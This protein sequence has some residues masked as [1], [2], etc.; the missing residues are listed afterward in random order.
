VIIESLLAAAFIWADSN[1]LKL[2]TPEP[3][4]RAWRVEGPSEV[5]GSGFP[6]P[7]QHG[8][9]KSI[10]AYFVAAHCP[11]RVKLPNPQPPPHQPLTHAG[12]SPSICNTIPGGILMRR[13]VGNVNVPVPDR[14]GL[15]ARPLAA[16]YTQSNP[17]I[18]ARKIA[19]PPCNPVNPP[20]PAQTKPLPVTVD[21][22]VTVTV[23]LQQ[24]PQLPQ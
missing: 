5:E 13:S 19:N 10:Q 21:T 24:S 4:E 2:G 23:K 6:D 22:P 18:P 20:Q 1:L 8:L 16:T 7:V 3:P 17:Q 9:R 12:N 11:R 14:L 15:Q